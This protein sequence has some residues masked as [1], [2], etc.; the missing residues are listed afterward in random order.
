MPTLALIMAL[1]GA[2]SADITLNP[3]G[4]FALVNNSA[5][6]LAADDTTV[7]VTHVG[8]PEMDRY[9]TA[10]GF[11]GTT[12]LTGVST[13]LGGYTGAAVKDGGDLTTLR[14]RPEPAFSATRT[15]AGSC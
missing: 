1:A 14:Q 2:A 9:S 5:G 8:R 3:T 10:G 11:L 15:I 4:S 7:Y 6:G 12:A 13:L